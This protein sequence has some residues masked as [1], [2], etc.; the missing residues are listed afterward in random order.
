VSVISE[1]RRE[2]GQA[3]EAALHQVRIEL[4]ADALPDDEPD[5]E[6]LVARLLQ[7]TERWAEACIAHR[8]LDDD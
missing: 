3:T 2:V 1:Q 6:Q 5:V 8:H 7:E 4:D